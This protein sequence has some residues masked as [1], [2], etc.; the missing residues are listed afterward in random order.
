M[1]EWG[2]L[3]RG[4]KY[5]RNDFEFHHFCFFFHRGKLEARK[6]ASDSLCPNFTYATVTLFI[7][8]H[9]AWD[10]TWKGSS[11]ENI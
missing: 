4:L 8:L 1:L 11:A 2:K 9:F 6:L 10:L 7:S 3:L 5:Q